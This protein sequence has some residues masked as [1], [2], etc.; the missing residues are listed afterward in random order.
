MWNL[1]KGWKKTL[2]EA[3]QAWVAKALF[4]E[5]KS[6]RGNLQLW[7][8]PP[9]PQLLPVQPPSSN[10]YFARPLFLWMPYRFWL[11]AFKCLKPEC[12]KHLTACGLYKQTRVVISIDGFYNLASE[13]L[14]CPTCHKKYISWSDA[15]LNQLDVGHRTYFPAL[16][17]YK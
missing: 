3:D 5:D 16:L 11:I 2:P 15:I 10:S 7:W 13:Y 6:L 9:Q 4:N 17:T 14:E 1:P 8:Y 12:T